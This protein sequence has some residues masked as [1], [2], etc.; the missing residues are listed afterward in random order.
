MKNKSKDDK[1]LKR[2]EKKNIIIEIFRLIWG[3]LIYSK[4][5]NNS[6]FPLRE[7]V[8]LVNREKNKELYI[9]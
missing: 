9:F 2:R 5:N 4:F 6:L 1:I 3:K 8:I 7:E